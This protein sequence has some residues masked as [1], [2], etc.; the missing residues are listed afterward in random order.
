MDKSELANLMLLWEQKRRELDQIEERITHA[1]EEIG[2][3]VKA[4]NVQAKYISGHIVYDYET[5]GKTAP[6]EIIAKHTN[7]KAVTS[8]A[9][10][11]EEA[12]LQAEPTGQTHPTVRVAVVKE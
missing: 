6:V 10:V 7:I 8:W 5:T 1:V 4:G 11:C 2:E 9:K 3:T 12:G